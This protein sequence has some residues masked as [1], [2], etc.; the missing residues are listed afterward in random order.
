MRTAIENLPDGVRELFVLHYTGGLSLRETA[1]AM[2]I[3][4]GTAK[5]RLSAGLVQ[6]RKTLQ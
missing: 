5:S 1:V 4:V 3:A 2:D 6:L